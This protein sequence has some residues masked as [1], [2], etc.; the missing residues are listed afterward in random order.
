MW[1]L[2]VKCRLSAERGARSAERLHFASL[3]S[4]GKFLMRNAECKM[5]NC[6]IPLCSTHK[7]KDLNKKSTNQKPCYLAYISSHLC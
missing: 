7:E 4:Q 3:H 5:Q 1:N 6:F 2:G